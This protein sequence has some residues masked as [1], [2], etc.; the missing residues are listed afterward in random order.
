[1]NADLQLRNSDCEPG[2]AVRISVNLEFRNSRF[3]VA[4]L[5]CEIRN[6]KFALCNAYL[7]EYN[8]RNKSD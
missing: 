3:E 4:V 6:S 2:K 8:K 5:P 7:N 1:M